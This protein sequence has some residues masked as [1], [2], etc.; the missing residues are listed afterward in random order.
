MVCRTTSQF[1]IY[2]WRRDNETEAVCNRFA[3]ALT[4]TSDAARGKGTSGASADMVAYLPMLSPCVLP[5]TDP[6]VDAHLTR[7][8]FPRGM[9]LQ[10]PVRVPAW[11]FNP[12]PIV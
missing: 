7:A 6:A 4:S 9:Q 11:V 12:L 10:L 1:G 8:A 5:S 3:A 2:A